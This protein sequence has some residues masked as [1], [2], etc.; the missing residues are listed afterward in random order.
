MSLLYHVF[1]LKFY[2]FYLLV[3]LYLYYLMSC[4]IFMLLILNLLEYPMEGLM[5]IYRFVYKSFSLVGGRSYFKWTVAEIL[6]EFQKLEYFLMFRSL[7][8][9][10]WVLV[11][12]TG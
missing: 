1:E 8:R 3:G 5:K 7:D 12:Q 10:G 6:V 11:F 9:S 4:T 2:Y